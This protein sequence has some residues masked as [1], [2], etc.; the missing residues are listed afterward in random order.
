MPPRPGTV[1][2]SA[3]AR[4][5]LR[6]IWAFSAGRWSEAQ[7]DRYLAAL[8]QAFLDLAAGERLGQAVTVQ[9]VPYLRSVCGAHVIFYRP[10]GDDVEVLRVLHA[11]MDASR[12]L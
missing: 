12:H 6:E 4:G 2:L 10:A 7:A 8:R 9:A 11:K 1:R 3:L 5:D